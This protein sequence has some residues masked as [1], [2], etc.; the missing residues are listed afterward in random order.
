MNTPH[1]EELY[2]ESGTLTLT[3]RSAILLSTKWTEC[4]RIYCIISVAED[5]D[6]YVKKG[7]SESVKQTG[8]PIWDYICPIDIYSLGRKLSPTTFK[9]EVYGRRLIIDDFL[10]QVILPVVNFADTNVFELRMPL[11]SEDKD[12]NGEIDGELDFLVHF[13]VDIGSLL[14]ESEIIKFYDHLTVLKPETKGAYTVG[15]KWKVLQRM[16]A[17]NEQVERENEKKTQPEYFVQLFREGEINTTRLKRL[18]QKLIESKFVEKFAS[19]DGIELL[20]YHIERLVLKS[21]NSAIMNRS[22]TQKNNDEEELSVSLL[23]VERIKSMANRVSISALLSCFQVLQIPDMLIILRILNFVCG[24]TDFQKLVE[25]VKLF[26]LRFR[27][28]MKQILSEISQ[29]TN[30]IFKTSFLEFLNVT[31]NKSP[32]M[33]DREILRTKYY[34]AGITYKFFQDLLKDFPDDELVEQVNIYLKISNLDG[35]VMSTK[36]QLN[37][38]QMDA[39]QLGLENSCLNAENNNLRTALQ[40]FK[41]RMIEG[42]PGD[43]LLTTPNTSSESQPSQTNSGSNSVDQKE[44][45][46]SVMLKKN[47]LSNSSGSGA[48]DKKTTNF[49]GFDF[50]P[51]ERFR[52]VIQL[53]MQAPTVPKKETRGPPNSKGVATRGGPA[54]PSGAGRRAPVAPKKGTEPAGKTANAAKGLDADDDKVT[55]S[56]SKMLTLRLKNITKTQDTIFEN[57]SKNNSELDLGVIRD[58]FTEVEKVKAPVSPRNDPS[59]SQAKKR[60]LMIDGRRQ[61]QLGIFLSRLKVTAEELVECFNK[62]TL[63]SPDINTELLEL[64]MG[65]F[66]PKFIEVE[67]PLFL[68]YTGDVEEL[69]TGEKFLYKLYRVNRIH[70]RIEILSFQSTLHQFINEAEEDQQTIAFGIEK[71]KSE[72]FKII[73]SYIVEIANTMTNTSKKMLGFQ[74][75]SLSQLTEVR[76]PSDKNMTVLHF[77]MQILGEKHPDVVS[78]ASQNVN[79]FSEVSKC[80]ANFQSFFPKLM[81]KL[82]VL[83]S[84]YQAAPVSDKIYKNKLKELK[85]SLLTECSA[86]TVKLHEIDNQIVFLGDFQNNLPENSTVKALKKLWMELKEINMFTSSDCQQRAKRDEERYMFFVVI[87]EFLKNMMKAQSYVEAIKL[88]KMQKDALNKKLEDEQPVPM[89]TPRN[90]DEDIAPLNPVSLTA[91]RGIPNAT[92]SI[93]V[94]EKRMSSSPDN[95]KNRIKVKCHPGPGSKRASRN[96]SADFQAIYDIH[97]INDLNRL[98]R[99]S[100]GS[101]EYASFLSHLQSS[102]PGSSTSTSASNDGTLNKQISSPVI[103]DNY[104]PD[105]QDKSISQEKTR[106][107]PAMKITTSP[108]NQQE[109]EKK[110]T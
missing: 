91:S 58:N 23:C 98:K 17:E 90:G 26:L 68:K 2:F 40:E 29:G 70:Q 21:S 43:D 65:I 92:P 45:L 31:L 50:M 18:R 74:F 99:S 3:V 19:L 82:H 53:V 41:R 34:K 59:A 46:K 32:T 12:W 97:D 104:I 60:E 13:S 103:V 25:N 83:E 81:K 94:E 64:L 9:I 5:G 38:L 54:P 89:T 102:S 47:E 1:F 77:L 36:E 86:L 42:T 4:S 51:D 80:I 108:S 24:K 52:N 44:L 62:I 76:S 56:P 93:S 39:N 6:S 73:L 57:I 55:K 14:T 27:S 101:G 28:T 100:Y 67:A 69:S 78:F 22:E 48:G 20:F 110:V 75:S 63:T 105:A 96:D 35:E 79:K 85:E 87:E 8:N 11:V 30:L 107:F 7:R 106:K 71:L 61:Q 109:Q 33:N 37:Q 49:F 66:S 84:E 88:K 72:E 10:G 16:H 95:Y 15:E